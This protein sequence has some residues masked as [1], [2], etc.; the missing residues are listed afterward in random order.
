MVFVGFKRCL[1]PAQKFSS[2]TERQFA[3]LL[4]D[5]ADPTL[6]WF[7]PARGQF[8]IVHRD[9][10]QYE[11]DFV[12][13]TSSRKLLIEI[14]AARELETDEVRS[15]A[16]AAAEWCQR[17]GAHEQQHGG[18]TWTY[19]LIPHDQVA[20]HRTLRSLVDAFGR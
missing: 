18:K 12:V 10:E 14:K 7:K 5:D 8:Q 20:P 17:A 19:A 11:P 2:D 3:I 6:R 15:K 4:E 1:Y 9:D 16:I 13:E